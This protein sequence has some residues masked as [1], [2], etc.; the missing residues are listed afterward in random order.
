MI[1]W[2]KN[3]SL[4]SWYTQRFGNLLSDTFQGNVSLMDDGTWDAWVINLS[5]SGK[6]KFRLGFRAK[7]PA[8]RWVN[9]ELKRIGVR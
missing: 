1:T 5:T 3:G 9:A 4:N 6:G 7:A 2:K 8:T